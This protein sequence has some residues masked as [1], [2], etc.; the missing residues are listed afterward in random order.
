MSII[1]AVCYFLNGLVV[2]KLGKRNLLV[3]WT[4]LCGLSSLVLVWTTDFTLILIFMVSLLASGCC[5]S[6]ISAISFDLFPTTIKATALCLI[7]MC[8]RLCAALGS[9]IIGWL[10]VINCNAV[11]WLVGVVLLGK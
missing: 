5:G 8:G 7:L 4:T 11:F 9:N 3:A 2:T 10:L 1:F 6:L